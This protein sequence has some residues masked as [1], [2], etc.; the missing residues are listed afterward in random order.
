MAMNIFKGGR[1]ASKIAIGL[2]LI[3]CAVV[4]LSVLFTKGISDTAD[5]WYSMFGAIVVPLMIVWGFTYATGYI[6]RG[7]LRIPKG[8]DDK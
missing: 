7:F 3:V 8:Q 2:W 4:I 1:R 5:D 6:I